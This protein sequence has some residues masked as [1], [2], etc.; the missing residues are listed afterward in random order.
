MVNKI[1]ALQAKPTPADAA[2]A[3][4]LAQSLLA[5]ADDRPDGWRPRRG[6]KHEQRSSCHAYLAKLKVSPM[7]AS[8]RGEV[9]VEV[10]A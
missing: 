2:D 3:L 1:L 4:A 10:G 5:G 7:I 8:V 6:R 9:L